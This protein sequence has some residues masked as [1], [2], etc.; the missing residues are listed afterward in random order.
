MPELAPL[1]AALAIRRGGTLASIIEREIERLITAG[2]F[3]SGQRLNE[4]ALAARLG[5]SRGPVREAVRALERAGLLRSVVNRGVFVRETSE[6]ELLEVYELRAVL[7]GFACARAAANASASDVAAL[8]RVLAAMEAARARGDEE[9]YFA[10]NV[11]F[12]EALLRLAASPRLS[13]IYADLVRTAR[14]FRQRSLETAGA[15]A[16]SNDEHRRIVAAIAAQDGRAARR[17]GEA[18]VLAGKRRFLAARTPQPPAAAAGKPR[19]RT[20]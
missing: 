4:N 8:R 9:G 6:P 10:T 13:E 2:E 17:E 7:T 3:A 1:S 5:V 16:E 12:H 15:M 14:L 20:P 19:R 11:E 18:H